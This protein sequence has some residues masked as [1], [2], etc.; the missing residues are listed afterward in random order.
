MRASPRRLS[1]S[2]AKRAWRCRSPRRKPPR[3]SGSGLTS[4]A[5]L[6]QRRPSSSGGCSCR[7]AAS[8]LAYLRG[9]GLSERRPFGVSALAGRAKGAALLLADLGR[10]GITPEQLVDAGL[11]RRDDETG[12][13]FDLFFNRVMFP[14]RD[15]RG[16][17]ISFGGRTLGD[18]QPKYLN[19]PE[20]ALFAK[21]RTLYGA[22]SWPREAVRSAAPRWWL[23]KAIWT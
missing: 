17:V 21:R 12:R 1:G 16:R 3:P 2:R 19:G 22:G 5:C 10:E 13:T 23:S 9:R 20:T 11:M 15:R 4:P 14:I 8:A 7:R 18:G 6:R